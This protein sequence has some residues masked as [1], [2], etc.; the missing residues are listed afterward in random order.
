M[1]VS[2]MPDLGTLQEEHMLMQ[3]ADSIFYPPDEDE[4]E[5]P[6]AL[7]TKHRISVSDLWSHTETST[8]GAD[9]DSV[10]S[11]ELPVSSP[12]TSATPR[13]SLHSLFE[14]Q[15]QP[16]PALAEE[17]ALDLRTVFPEDDSQV[18]RWHPNR[19]LL[20]LVQLAHAGADKRFSRRRLRQKR[21]SAVL[22]L[23]SMFT[24][25]YKPGRLPSSLRTAG[26]DTY[27]RVMSVV[28]GASIRTTAKATDAA[29]TEL[30][31]G[32]R[33]AWADMTRILSSPMGRDLSAKLRITTIHGPT[34]TFTDKMEAVRDATT[35]INLT[36]YGFSMCFNTDFGQKN[37]E[38]VKLVQS[39]LRGAEL[40]TALTKLPEYA[41]YFD[42]FYEHFQKLGQELGVPLVACGMEHS[43]NGDHP[44]RIHLHCYAG[45]DV[46]GGIYGRAPQEITVP[47]SCLTFEGLRPSVGV[48]TSARKRNVAIHT[49]VVQSY[50]YVAGPKLGCLFSR[51]VA[52][53]FK[54]DA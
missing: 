35:H 32:H 20:A 6:R 45:I 30:S 53:L 16:E 19:S 17:V 43:E 52:V 37:V 33:N 44:A 5:S 24:K 15:S 22:V 9:E 42:R 48:T 31:L 23:H 46:R 39:G 27:R 36:G 50:Y 4:H 40:R 41:D 1:D 51:G 21:F 13:L 29:W 28:T 3:D 12:V 49:A 47:R 10:L 7:S 26:R 11:C 38:T 34:R 8:L 14:A 2:D 25:T 54:V 18:L